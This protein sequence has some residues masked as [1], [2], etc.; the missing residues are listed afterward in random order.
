LFVA[1]EGTEGAGKTT[2][3]RLLYRSLGAVPGEVLAVQ[4][5][6]YLSAA[7]AKVITNAKFHGVIYPE[8]LLTAA[9]IADKEV[10]CDRI[11]GP[12]RFWRTVI[13][14]RWIISDVVYNQA[15]FGVP[16][17]VTMRAFEASR[18]LDPDLVILVDTPPAVAWPRILNR[19][20]AH[21]HRWDSPT[22]LET[23][24]E[25][26]ATA[27]CRLPQDTVFRLPNDGS[28]EQA[29][30]LALGELL[31][32]SGQADRQRRDQAGDR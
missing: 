25:L 22:M 14:D 19:R 12:H 27:T 13:A 26:F 5:Q 23:L 30:S 28:V 32:R 16:M 9:T 18:V 21:P 29:A 2:I 31:A 3:R 4:G 10:L 7:H 20:P 1:I 15:L 8:D 24:Y 11:I 6:S 17:E